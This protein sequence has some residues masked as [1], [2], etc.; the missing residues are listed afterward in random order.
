MSWHRMKPM[1]LI[2][3]LAMFLMLIGWAY[4]GLPK[5]LELYQPTWSRSYQL[6]KQPHAVWLDRYESVGANLDLLT[7]VLKEAAQHKQQPEFVV[8]AIPLRDL[9]QSSEGGFASYEDYLADNRMNADLIVKFVKATGIHPVMYLEPDSIPL[10]VQYRR[11]HNANAESQQIYADRIRIMNALTELFHAAGAKVYLEAGHSGW[12]DYGD[13]DVQRIADALNEAGVSK[14]DGL[15]T[16]VSNRQP[17]SGPVERTESHYLSRLL[18]R[19]D[20]KH[21]DV[22]VDTSRNGGLTIPRQYYLHP[23]GHLVDNERSAGRVVGLWHKDSHGETW[24]Q[25]F[26]GAPKSLTRLTT[27][28]KFSYNTAK[29]LITAPP[30]LDAVGDV[31]PGPAPTDTPGLGVASVIQHY[32]YIKPPDDC[33]GALNCPP[34]MSKHDINAETAKRQPDKPLSLPK[35]LW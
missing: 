28:E 13:E 16:N 22:R 27:K 24:F 32:R 29:Q 30:W 6:Y 12:F 33:D 18:P 5:P 7:K 19:L 34:G 3:S 1:L 8:Y 9:G 25:P 11:D 21:L 17:V 10:A 15:A 26:F 20:N 4:T 2:L 31:K 14:A 35:G 23:D